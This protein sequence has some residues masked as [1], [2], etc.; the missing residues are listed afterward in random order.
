MKF[1][2]VLLIILVA[3][4]IEIFPTDS[5]AWICKM[6]LYL[7]IFRPFEKC[8]LAVLRFTPLTIAEKSRI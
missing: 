3:N 6:S 1:W 4:L 5:V 2:M 8:E 7:I